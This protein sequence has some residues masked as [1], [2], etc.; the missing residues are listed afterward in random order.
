MRVS[1]SSLQR[2]SLPLI[3]I[4]LRPYR[5]KQPIKRQAVKDGYVE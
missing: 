1:K 2:A 3:N 4:T 5:Q